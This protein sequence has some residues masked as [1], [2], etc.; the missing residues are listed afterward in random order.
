MKFYSFQGDKKEELTKVNNKTMGELAATYT[1]Y[2]SPRGSNSQTP[3]RFTRSQLFLRNDPT[4][5]LNP[6]QSS[7][8]KPMLNY[9]RTL[10][11]V[12]TFLNTL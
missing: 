12:S 7:I 1:V 10:R 2:F 11:K 9:L 5:F 3:R 6:T 4:L 8:K